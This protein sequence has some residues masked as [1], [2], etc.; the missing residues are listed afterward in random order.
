VT[1]A[2]ELSGCDFFAE[3]EVQ[4]AEGEGE[5]KMTVLSIQD[6][7]QHVMGLCSEHEIACFECRRPTEA[8]AIWDLSEIGIPPIKS[9]ISYGTALHEIGHIL[10]RHQR[11][12]DSMVRERWAWQW[13]KSNALIWTD[14]LDRYAVTSLGFAAKNKNSATRSEAEAFRQL[15]EL[16]LKVKPK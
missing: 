13:A 4:R 3:V 14:V 8:W 7:R 11:S 10:G 16:G 15:V 9:A 1:C 5:V 12:R 2:A 6:M